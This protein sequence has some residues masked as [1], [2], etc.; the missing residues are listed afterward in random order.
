MR[1]AAGLGAL[2]LSAASLA[3]PA[4]SLAPP[5]KG[6]WAKDF[7]GT[8]KPQTL[9]ALDALAAKVDASGKG[10][11]GV[12]VVASTDGVPSRVYATRVFNHWG[13]GH[14]GTN[15]GVLL[16]VA[17]NERKA[18][19]VL[20]D[21]LA[22]IAAAQTDVVMQTELVP[23][24]K[25][26]DRDGGLLHAAM[27]LAALVQNRS[28]SV[29]D[30]SPHA[31]PTHLVPVEVPTVFHGALLEA[32][33][34][35]GELPDPS[36]R[37][38]VLDDA[39]SLSAETKA[40]V[41]RLGDGAWSE[42]HG[43]FFLLVTRAPSRDEAVEAGRWVHQTLAAKHGGV[44]WLLHWDGRLGITQVW[45]QAVQGDE[46]MRRALARV[47]IGG[48]NVADTASD[49]VQLMTHGAPALTVTERFQL[50]ATEL[51]A[52]LAAVLVG[53][54][55][56]LRR[57]LRMRPRVCTNCQRPR[58]RLGEDADDVHLN[59][60]QK[61]EEQLGTVDYDVWWCGR[62][63][64]PLVIRYGAL[65]TMHFACKSCGFKTATSSSTTLVHATYD[66]GGQVQVTET[67]KHCSHSHSFIRY[68]SRLTRPSESSSS[69]NSFS[70]GG[71]S[72]SSFGGGSSSGRGS[73]GSW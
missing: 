18:E 22:D 68:T 40:S 70:S 1:L 42:N 23:R 7:T 43:R 67:C 36:P 65:F 8:V 2:L 66:H 17:V 24:F 57:W 6:R 61:R 44:V 28:A 3:A 73:S 63:N 51:F 45:P 30:A 69:S 31:P 50:H 59:E 16:F 14:Q 37:G 26:G 60:G 34:G 41:D 13:V 38:W 11:L 4:E 55:L 39:E 46:A 64:D 15:D 48:K 32:Y 5:E 49:V 53:G 47:A 10:Q 62:C 54:G 29:P 27:A 52:A 72:S 71:G 25:Q 21:G 56:W 58:E 33:R 12:A 35:R 9:A 20:G 19:I